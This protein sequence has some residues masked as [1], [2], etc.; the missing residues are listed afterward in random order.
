MN[1]YGKQTTLLSSGS[2]G[3]N[4][5]NGL[6]VFGK[7]EGVDPLRAATETMW[8]NDALLKGYLPFKNNE[9]NGI[10]H[11][12]NI[13]AANREYKPLVKGALEYIK[14]GQVAHSIKL[15]QPNITGENGPEIA[16]DFYNTWVIPNAQELTPEV[17][18]Q[19]QKEV[20]TYPLNLHYQRW[21]IEGRDGGSVPLYEQSFESIWGDL[22]D[23]NL[24]DYPAVV[25]GT[26][27]S[28][29]TFMMK[30]PMNEKE[31]EGY[32]SAMKSIDIKLESD[33]SFQALS[34]EKAIQGNSQ[35]ETLLP[36]MYTYLSAQY[37]EN[38]SAFPL[39]DFQTSNKYQF[40]KLNA[41]DAKS[42]WLYANKEGTIDGTHNTEY[43]NQFVDKV[44]AIQTMESQNSYNQKQKNICIT[45]KNSNF[46]KDFNDKAVMFPMWNSIDMATDRKGLF[47]EFI[48]ESKMCK[49]LIKSLIYS[50]LTRNLDTEVLGGSVP[51][52]EEP[53]VI[54]ELTS[55][56]D[57]ATQMPLAPEAEI[58]DSLVQSQDFSEW[59][60]AFLN[61]G[62]AS[63]FDYNSVINSSTYIGEEE[64]KQLEDTDP[65]YSFYHSLLG[66]MLTGK[67]NKVI[68]E[69]M[70]TYD[71]ILK[72]KSAYNEILL[73]R[74]AKHKITD[75]GTTNPVPIQNFWISNSEEID[76]I[77]YYDTQ[78]KYKKKYKYLI[79]AYTVVV[80]TEYEYSDLA[81]NQPKNTD[82]D[83]Q[84]NNCEA[85]LNVVC[86]PAIRLFQV[87]YY[88][89]APQ[90]DD[91]VTLTP[92]DDPPTPP[93]PQFLPVGGSKRKMKIFINGGVDEFEAFPT[94]IQ[95]SDASIYESIRKT[96]KKN[97]N[98]KLRFQSDDPAAKFQVFR[99]NPDAGTGETKRPVSYQDFADALHVTLNENFSAPSSAFV[100]DLQPEKKYYYCF[101]S[102]DNHGNISPP[103]KVY[104]V[105]I[106]TSG[107]DSALGYPIIKVVDFEEENTTKQAT[108]AFRKYLYLRANDGQVFIPK[109]EG[110]DNFTAAK[111]KP[112]QIG[113]LQQHLFVPKSVADGDKNTNTLKRFK[114]RLTSKKSGKK[115]DINVGFNYTVEE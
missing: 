12:V 17:K 10:F 59:I 41:Q 16:Q 54:N 84:L 74:V 7:G 78:V 5:L 112:T 72:G 110:E 11:L 68:R 42:L 76:R 35:L 40:K 55:Q 93:I 83:Q 88:G 69:K 92:Q 81:Y 100:D 32:G 49:T 115:I 8:D 50:F 48:H 27:F 29:F 107:D 23:Y 60:S 113:T 61:G 109:I 66:L 24:L 77:K 67:M 73:Y 52:I 26:T 87:P 30:R 38:P 105:I 98:E 6:T 56:I 75:Q 91:Y 85:Y 14:P 3:L 96:Q 99:I 19:L 51:F 34:Y 104:E 111:K 44:S 4:D 45:A 21:I 20:R 94:M 79:Y 65:N 2:F 43:F 97:S 53:L 89:F 82:F 70:R 103:T 102:L 9:K 25:Q 58:R 39:L 15:V 114:I 62:E 36:N 33:Y 64:G 1:A 31:V 46:I 101:R 90:E 95:N 28:D 63:L 86:T 13:S 47:S 106:K 37:A 18:G 80:G 22:A 71:E 57:P 108:K